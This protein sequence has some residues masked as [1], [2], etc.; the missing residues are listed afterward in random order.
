M[1]MSAKDRNAR[2]LLKILQSQVE[3]A[4]RMREA[5][6]AERRAMVVRDLDGLLTAVSRKLDLA[7]QMKEAE[8]RRVH[9]LRAHGLEGKALSDIAV[10]FPDMGDALLQ[11]GKALRRELEE[12]AG[13]SQANAAMLKEH[14]RV[15]RS[16]IGFLVGLVQ[17]GFQYGQEGRLTTGAKPGGRLVDREA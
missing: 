14:V 4:A 15:V 17:S 7:A 3:L 8:G 12:L 10:A 13:L 16:T 11:E 5:L 9:W 2:Q 6:A 1:T